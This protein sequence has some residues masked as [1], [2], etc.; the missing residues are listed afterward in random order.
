MSKGL[1][2]TTHAEE[3]VMIIELSGELT[4]PD[5]ILPEQIL[6][7]DTQIM[8]VVFNFTAVEYI[9]SAGIALLIRL[10]RR[11]REQQAAV[12]AYGV[13]NHYQ[14]I[15]NMVGLTSYLYLYP[16]EATALAAAGL[17]R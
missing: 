11:A 12:L 8:A 3:R 1:I 7:P 15:F 14:K 10:V 9:N 5:A 17:I 13:S 6:P 16:D 4:K 2:I